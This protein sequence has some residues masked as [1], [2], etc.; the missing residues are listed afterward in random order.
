MDFR[1]SESIKILTYQ[2][3]FL[4]YRLRGLNNLRL[5]LL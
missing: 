1:G 3:H 2:V 4:R 5:Y